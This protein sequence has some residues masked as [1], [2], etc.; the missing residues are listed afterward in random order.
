MTAVIIIFYNNTDFL[1]RQHEHLSLFM[2]DEYKLIVIDNSSDPVA[3]AGMKHHA[4]EKG[5]EYVRTQ[6]S[7]K[8]GSASHAFALCFAYQKYV[9]KF[10]YI[11]L[12]DHDAFLIKPLSAIE[13]LADKS[14]AGLGQIRNGEKYFWPGCCMFKTSIPM[15]FSISEGKDTGGNTSKAIQSV[16]EENCIFFDEVYV[17]NEGFNKSQYN[18]YALLSNGT[19]LHFINGSNWANSTDNEERLNSLFNVLEN[20]KNGT[21][22]I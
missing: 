22:N 5:L 3:A 21:E 14:I 18:F 4:D 7:S 6:S 17:Q 9:N 19:F 10:E 1:L 13:T 20:Y 8:N 12:L 11:L 16:G 2:K 15:D